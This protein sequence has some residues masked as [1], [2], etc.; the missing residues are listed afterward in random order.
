MNGQEKDDEI[1]G[2][3][4]IMSAEYWEYDT[5]LGRR[6]N[7]DPIVKPW[8]SSYA[9]F[10]DN[11]IY[12]ADPH[13]LSSSTVTPGGNTD[14]NTSVPEGTKVDQ[15][16]FPLNH[17][18]NSLK[19]PEVKIV[20]QDNTAVAQPNV[21]NPNAQHQS[22]SSQSALLDMIANRLRRMDDFVNNSNMEY[23]RPPV[24]TDFWGFMS[25]GEGGSKNVHMVSPHAS[26]WADGNPGSLLL[27]LGKISSGPVSKAYESLNKIG[28]GI[29]AIQYF[30]DG[31]GIDPF[32]PQNND[33]PMLTV[34]ND[35]T[36]KLQVIRVYY[37]I[38]NANDDMVSSETG[39]NVYAPGDTLWKETTTQNSSGNRHTKIKTWKPRK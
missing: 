19:F 1:A 20:P 12:F 22:P 27:S 26:S 10:S 35:K 18:G 9:C 17:D 2:A 29:G 38:N 21:P 6:W 39:D 28:D 11:P 8:E 13:G 30:I 14:K 16:D 5:R 4:N 23:S 36:V 32:A 25:F 24:Q 3:G 33:K 15:K 34:P 37:M 31:S 7:T